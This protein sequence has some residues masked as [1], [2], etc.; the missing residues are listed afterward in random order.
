MSGRRQR[1][2]GRRAL[3]WAGWGACTPATPPGPHPNCACTV[4]RAHHA[5]IALYKTHPSS[6]TCPSC[7]REGGGSVRGAS[8]EWSTAATCTGLG[9]LHSRP[10]HIP[11]APAPVPTAPTPSLAPTTAAAAAAAAAAAVGSRSQP[12]HPR[13]ACTAPTSA[14]QP[15]T[16]AHPPSAIH[17]EGAMHGRARGRARA[18]GGEVEK[19]GRGWGRGRNTA[20]WT[21]PVESCCAPF[22]S[23]FSLP[24]FFSF[25][26]FL[27]ASANE[28]KAPQCAYT[29]N[30]CDS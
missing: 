20:T 15:H 25:F 19:S 17:R 23:F 9:C 2:M 24:S 21:L 6:R 30:A 29:K 26:S 4:A 18:A 3:C 8:R 28:C 16:S 11:T 13:C 14:L 10:T 27:S 12:A 5:L 22:F 1:H 7:L